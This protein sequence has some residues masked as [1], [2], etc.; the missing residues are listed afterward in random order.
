MAI[1]PVIFPILPDQAVSELV[2]RYQ[3]IKNQKYPQQS[4]DNK[5]RADLIVKGK[6]D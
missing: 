1:P 5:A 3:Q 4:N 6:I 2:K